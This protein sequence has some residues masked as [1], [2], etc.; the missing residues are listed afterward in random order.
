[1]TEQS[2]KSKMLAGELYDARDPELVDLRRRARRLTKA[3]NET[4]P[5]D[6]ADRKRLLSELF[7]SMQKG[8]WIEPPFYFCYGIYIGIS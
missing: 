7:G 1:M 4:G 6:G 5:D 8:V 2:E 3:F